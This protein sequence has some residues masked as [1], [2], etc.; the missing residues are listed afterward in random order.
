MAAP[1]FGRDPAGSA[2]RSFEW[3]SLFRARL[4]VVG[5]VL[6]RAH[7]GVHRYVGA[8]ALAA[9]LAGLPVLGL[10]RELGLALEVV[11]QGAMV[12]Y[13]GLL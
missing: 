8:L 4:G 10:D 7:L 9:P 5:V 3:L 12:S 2:F 1:G 11:V 6:Q 13:V